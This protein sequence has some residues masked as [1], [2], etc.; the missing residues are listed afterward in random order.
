MVGNLTDIMQ[1]AIRTWRSVIFFDDA[2]VESRGDDQKKKEPRE[3]QKLKRQHG[4][5]GPSI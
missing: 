5:Y 1:A 4:E 2:I 3:R